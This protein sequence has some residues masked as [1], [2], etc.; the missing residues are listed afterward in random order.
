MNNI[1]LII[2]I[3]ISQNVFSWECPE[4]NN[5]YDLDTHWKLATDV[6]WGKVVEGKYT[7]RKDYENDI[8]FTV[9]IYDIFK[10]N[11]K[12][13]VDL[14]TSHEA[15]F[16]GVEI[17]E[18]YI[19]FLYGDNKLDFCGILVE[20][21]HHIETLDRLNEFYSRDEGGVLK[22]IKYVQSHAQK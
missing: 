2:L 8:D 15:L 11:L 6:F 7:K 13:K 1:L 20:V 22:V 4:T 9:E 12:N 5:S 3:L 14:S 17:G 19:F 21:Q 10:G 16:H 18:N